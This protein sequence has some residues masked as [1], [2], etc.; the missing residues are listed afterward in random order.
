[1][2]TRAA[3]FLP[4]FFENVPLGKKEVDKLESLG[5]HYDADTG[6]RARD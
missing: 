5:I 6:R 2:T 3:H 4:N 1:M